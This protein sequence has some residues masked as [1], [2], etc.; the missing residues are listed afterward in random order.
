MSY[1]ATNWQNGV[2]PINEG[3]LNKIEQGIVDAHTAVETA[4]SALETHSQDENNPH[5]VTKEQVGL[6]NVDNTADADK[7]IS[8]A[9]QEAID[10]AVATLNKKIASIS[11]GGDGTGGGTADVIY[12]D[13]TTSGLSAS[14]VQGAIDEVVELASSGGSGNTESVELTQEEYDALGDVVNSNDITYFI[15]DGVSSGGSGSNSELEEKVDALTESLNAL[16]TGTPIE[17]TPISTFAVIQNG[18]CLRGDGYLAGDFYLTGYKD[19]NN[20]YIPE[21]TVYIVGSVPL[22]LKAQITFPIEMNGPSNSYASYARGTIGT[23]GIVYV[24]CAGAS[25]N[26]IR[27]IVA[28]VYCKVE[29]DE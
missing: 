23:D 2:T 27:D 19:G 21:K 24:Y 1:T 12:Y 22:R 10:E 9:T 14:D 7:P 29:L 13:N 6:G 17:V 16:I 20:T 18:L 11:T 15:K 5:G 3:N 26:T 28:Q 4:N 25:A 8:T